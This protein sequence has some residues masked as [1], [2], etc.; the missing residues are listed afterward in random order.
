M[1]NRV[2]VAVGVVVR[3][4]P[5]MPSGAGLEGRGW[6][7]L[8]A[9]RHDH[10]VLGG[11]WELPGGKIEPGET[12]EACTIREIKEELDITVVVDH[13]LPT[14]EY[15][16][17]HALVRLHPFV[18]SLVHGQPANLQVAEHRWVRP[19][20]LAHYPFPDGNRSLMKAI[21]DHLSGRGV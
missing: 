20:E 14:T 11:L 12:P 16:Y 8:I 13:P 4:T 7:V 18:C 6:E 9:R 21:I 5:E 3:P 17:D 19:H 1:L 10:T 2:D 15:P